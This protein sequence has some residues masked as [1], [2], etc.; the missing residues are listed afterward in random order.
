MGVNLSTASVSLRTEPYSACAVS[1][2]TEHFHEQ[3]NV[4]GLIPE[5]FNIV[6]YREL[7]QLRRTYQGSGN[8]NVKS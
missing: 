5:A 4:K 8:C 7:G 3:W 6:K 2:K 1:N